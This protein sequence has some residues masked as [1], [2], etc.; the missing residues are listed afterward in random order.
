VPI[1]TKLCIVGSLPD[2]ITYAK[3]QVEMFR[4]YNFTGGRM[5]HFSVDFCMGLTTALINA[6]PGPI[7]SY[8]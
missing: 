5:S 1:R 3:F 6:N 7:H 2:I 4:D 8:P